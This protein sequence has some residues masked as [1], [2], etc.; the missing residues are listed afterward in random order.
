[1]VICT[2]C[3]DFLGEI[4]N[5]F[6]RAVSG[7][8]ALFVNLR[9]KTLK[10]LKLKRLAPMLLS[11]LRS[12]RRRRLLAT[13]FPVEWS[14]LLEDI[15]QYRLLSSDEQGK[16]RDL[17][18]IFI[19]EKEF[20]GCGGLGITNAM[21]VAIAAQAC[22][23]LLGFHDVFF[24]NVPTILVYPEAFVA[25]DQE[26]LGSVIL[27][28]ESDRLGEAHYRGPLILSWADVDW[29][30]RHA[31]QGSNLVFHEF[32][33]QLDMLNGAADGVPLL[34]RPLRQRWKRVMAREYQRLCRAADRGRDTL[35]DP[36]GTTD[37]AEFF[38]V[39]TEC[40]FDTP[41]D[42]KEQHPELYDLFQEYYQQ[43][44]LNRGT[45][46]QPVGPAS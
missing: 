12:R 39:V 5:T 22:I 21:C 25:P 11:W 34:A 36:Y 7:I 43:D 35:I 38:A 46:F 17:V 19:A 16:L 24:D 18:R 14:G 32:A 30:A 2:T 23:L 40:F 20:E 15:A 44:P 33:H 29:D 6:F 42:M 41:R 27:E 37:P 8:A 1:V 10:R 28:H 45:G 26:V 9:C 13:P 3:A 31:G 4:E